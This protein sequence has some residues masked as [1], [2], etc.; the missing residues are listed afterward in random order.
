MRLS[1]GMVTFTLPTREVVLGT[2]CATTSAELTAQSLVVC[3]LPSP[4]TPLTPPALLT[5]VPEQ[6][7]SRRHFQSPSLTLPVGFVCPSRAPRAPDRTMPARPRQQSP[8]SKG[9][10]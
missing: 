8:H 6:E 5:G 2:V 10:S 3:I 4:S 1:A 9:A 7:C